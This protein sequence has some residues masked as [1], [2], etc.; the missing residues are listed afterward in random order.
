MKT[1][2]L[3]NHEVAD[4]LEK[5]KNLAKMYFFKYGT[6]DDEIDP[7]HNPDWCARQAKIEF[8]FYEDLLEF[9]SETDDFN[10]EKVRK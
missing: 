2:Y 4:R 10:I 6:Y 3:C 8:A 7:L 5:D 9:L 1:L